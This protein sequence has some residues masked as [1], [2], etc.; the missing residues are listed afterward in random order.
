[1]DST[2]KEKVDALITEVSDIH[3]MTIKVSVLNYIEQQASFMLWQLEDEQRL[4]EMQP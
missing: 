4:N 1:M 3:D 2:F